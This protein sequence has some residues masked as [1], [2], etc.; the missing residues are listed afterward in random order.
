MREPITFSGNP[1]DRVSAR[2]KDPAWLEERSGAPDSRYLVFSKLQ[3]LSNEGGLLWLDMSIREVLGDAEPWLLGMRDGVAHF[4]VDL[5]AL[6]DP[7]ATLGLSNARFSEARSL[8]ALLPG[9]DSGIV[10]HGRALMEWHRRHRFCGACGQPTMVMEGGAMRKCESCGQDH[11]PRTDPAV[12]MLVWR[13]DRCVLGRQKVWAPG[14]YSALAGF[15]DQG[16]TIEEAVRREVYEEVGLVVDEV[17]YHA[18]QPWP[19]PMNLMIGCFAHAT[20]DDLNI[21]P[22]ELDT[23]RWFSVEEV[24]RAIESPDPSLGFS[25]PGRIAIAHH[26]IKD[27]SELEGAHTH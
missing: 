13:G 19:F 3:V 20:S 15:V 21:D 8:A 27:W 7:I 23:A 4:A 6:E 1:L 22:D 11:F 14:S 24:R 12:I 26:L 5:S 25:V 16:E 9:E 2:R 10:A 17:T 18:S